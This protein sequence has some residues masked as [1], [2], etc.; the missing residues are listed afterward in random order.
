MKESDSMRI[1][2]VFKKIEELGEKV[3]ELLDITGYS[4]YGDLDEVDANNKDELLLYRE[5]SSILE[6]LEDIQKRIDYLK[7]PIKYQGRLLK[8]REGRYEIDKCGHYYTSGDNI[9]AYIEEDE[10][11]TITRVE[12]KNN[13]YYLVGYKEVD[14][15]NL[16]VRVR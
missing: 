10:E 15:N 2:N 8:N 4:K 11:W 12:Y 5:S 16:L 14:M 13:D 7:K 3:N 1:D 6:Q 9:E